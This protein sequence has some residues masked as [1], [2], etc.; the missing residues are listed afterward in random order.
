MQE[1]SVGEPSYECSNLFCV[2]APISSPRFV[3]PNGPGHKEKGEP[4]ER[5]T[6]ELIHQS[7]KRGR[8][9][10]RLANALGTKT[11]KRYKKGSCEGGDQGRK[12]DRIRVQ[13]QVE[14]RT[15]RPDPLLGYLGQLQGTN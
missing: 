5:D 10:Q 8:R 13:A 11:K 14:F 7:V 3:R 2:P 12:L 1:T 15:I 9:R 4:R 6:A